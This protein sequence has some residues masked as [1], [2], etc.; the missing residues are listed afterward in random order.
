MTEDLKDQNNANV[1]GVAET[2]SANA[3]Q[4][5]KLIPQ[6]EVN[7]LVGGIKTEA[8]EKGMRQGLKQSE[9]ANV[10]K[11]E[12][13]SN[14]NVHPANPVLALSDEDLERKRQ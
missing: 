9:S 5:E 11:H 13:V 14:N 4:S 2:N 12:P 7:R 6:S 10:V 3:E 8:F 1:E